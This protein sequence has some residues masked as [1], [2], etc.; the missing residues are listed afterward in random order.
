MFQMLLKLL[1]KTKVYNPFLKELNRKVKINDTK[2]SYREAE[3][4]ML[5][6]ERIHY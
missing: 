2:L 1:R 3:R 6:N 5:E 4:L